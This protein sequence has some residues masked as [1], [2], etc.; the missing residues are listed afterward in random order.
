MSAIETGYPRLDADLEKVRDIIDQSDL[1]ELLQHDPEKILEITGRQVFSL[2]VLLASEDGREKFCRA[3]PARARDDVRSLSEAVASKFG[4]LLD[5]KVGEELKRSIIVGEE[6]FPQDE[7]YDAVRSVSYSGFLRDISAELLQ[8]Y[9]RV[10]VLAPK[11]KR[12]AALT[13]EWD[14]CL[15]LCTALMRVVCEQMDRFQGLMGQ[16]LLAV[17]AEVLSDRSG[18][19]SETLAELNERIENYS[20]HTGRD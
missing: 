18:D 13:M 3:L 10:N 2:I 1:D 11:N 8:P 16:R 15:F 19:V 14:D 17:D 4:A 20:Q 6:D 7:I 9:I 5:S 12:I